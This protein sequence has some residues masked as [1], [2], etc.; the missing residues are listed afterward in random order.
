M[1]CEK[2]VIE[3]SVKQNIHVYRV[4]QNQRPGSLELKLLPD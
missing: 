2:L 3:S 1:K 4:L